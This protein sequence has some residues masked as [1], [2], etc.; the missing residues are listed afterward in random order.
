MEEGPERYPCKICG[1]KASDRADLMEHLRED[2]EILEALS[3]AAS[4]MIFEI[5]RD[6]DASKVYEQWELIKKEMGEQERRCPKC[7]HRNRKN[8]RFCDNCNEPL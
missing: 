4:T 5:E 8:A 3:Y 7:D 1:A 6:R 2:H